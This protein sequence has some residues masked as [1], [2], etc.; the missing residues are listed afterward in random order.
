M[1]HEEYA[2]ELAAHYKI[3]PQLP[4]HSI[5][6][7]LKNVLDSKRLDLQKLY[8]LKAGVQKLR[9]AAGKSVS[10][11]IPSSNDFMTGPN[12]AGPK[13][14]YT[15]DRKSSRV[16]TSAV[17]KSINSDVQDLAE[18]IRDLETSL[19]LLKHCQPSFDQQ[20][21]VIKSTNRGDSIEQRLTE[22]QKALDIELQVRSGAERLIQTYKSGPRHFL[23]EARKQY[24]NANNKIGFIRNQMI[25][26][27]Q[28][29]EGFY[30]PD[31]S[32]LGSRSENISD[33]AKP[34]G[35]INSASSVSSN[36][37]GFLIW[38][39]KVMELAHRLRVERALFVG[40]KKAVS[41]VLD[42]QIHVDKSRKLQA[43]QEARESLH[44]LYL[45]QESIKPLLK[46]PPPTH[47]PDMI[48]SIVDDPEMAVL[49]SSP[50][51]NTTAFH[52]NSSLLIPSPPTAIT[53]SLEVRCLGCQDIVDHFPAEIVNNELSG[54]STTRIYSVPSVMTSRTSENHWVDVRCSLL[55]DHKRVWDSPWRQPNQ[56]CWDSKTT[57]N[58]DRGKELEVQVYW[59]RMFLPSSSTS[60]SG[61]SALSKSGLSEDSGSGLEWVLAAVNYVR[62]EELLGGESRSVMLPMLPMGKVFLVLK[63]SDPLLSK[64]RCGLHRQKRLFS[65]RKGNNIPRINELDMN[66]PL[67][68]RLLKS[69]Q[70][71][72]MN[73]SVIGGSWTLNHSK[74][75]GSSGSVMM[76]GLEGRFQQLNTSLSGSPVSDQAFNGKSHLNTSKYRESPSAF[77]TR[78]VNITD[79]IIQQRPLVTII[80]EPDALREKNITLTE[81]EIKTLRKKSLL[82]DDINDYSSTSPQHAAATGIGSSF[83]PDYDVA[84]VI[85]EYDTDSNSRKPPTVP[86]VSDYASP[87]DL[88]TTEM[89]SIGQKD[90]DSRTADY[91]NMDVQRSN[92]G[93]V[94]L[95]TEKENKN[96]PTSESPRTAPSEIFS[97]LSS[98]KS[99]TI[100][101]MIDF[102]TVAVLGRGHFGKVLL[103]QYH[104]DNKYYAIKSLKKAEIIFRNEVDTLL[105]EK[106]ILQII[107]D[108]QHP[109]LINLIACFQTK[110]HVMFVMEYA[111]G[112][113]LMSLIQKNVFKEPQAVFYAG[114]VVLGI[115]FLHSKKIV[116]R[117]LKL[118]NLLL[119]S[120]GF[121]KMA[122]FGLCKEGMGPDDR[123]STFC[124][125]PEFLAP[126][127]LTDSS[128]TRAVDWW[129]LGVL[130]FEML[131]GE[132]PFPGESEEE[133]FDS[134]VNK[135]VC[136]PNY[137]S[138]EA[139]LIMGRLLRRNA[140]QRLGSSAQ[141]A[142]EIK[143]QPFFRKLDFQ[144]LLAQKIKPPFVPVVSGPED[145]SNFD[146][147]FTREKAVLT[148][149]KQRPPLLD[150]DQLNFSNFD[151]Y[152]HLV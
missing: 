32:P 138:M 148:P 59:K 151:Y 73:R 92:S 115:E 85:I 10:A 105:T 9:D 142:E 58:I 132:C 37:E 15:L 143:R 44:R 79:T 63:F 67:W 65:K 82:T 107:T 52:G 6:E 23:E 91:I 17:I 144:A 120:E 50:W 139:K 8:K 90:A 117:D 83:S 114:C 133:I 64:P 146:E 22:L 27:K 48:S 20:S 147:E 145:V 87:E 104:R 103:S 47:F 123:T 25:R 93:P 89:I 128:Y 76:H 106:R 75:F 31:T 94:V 80:R 72:K 109:F 21:A 69:G 19:L 1:E 70:L 16:T 81:K 30:Q 74:E 88:G 57:F 66:I 136:Y 56:Q 140:A 53:G 119:D 112:G 62:L 127:V 38:K 99:T 5:I 13:E 150:A 35:S 12:S 14:G 96:V 126:E 43:L 110:E 121:V 111:Q 118:D 135:S 11:V 84:P 77:P 41:A 149:T 134:I 152:S 2:R 28:M 45:F 49:L 122:D 42:N 108:A 124:G 60:A 129:G 55:I 4:Y 36:Q 95:S 141:D 46:R 137:L 86:R 34:N 101:S 125:T 40:S 18:D 51:S 78:S 29:N 33:T 71:S 26:V 98:N 24:E 3:S 68:T 61:S 54:T 102:R 131:V 130:I 116:Y 100:L 113:D 7:E 97:E 39:D